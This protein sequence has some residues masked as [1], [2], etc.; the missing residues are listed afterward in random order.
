MTGS[1]TPARRNAILAVVVLA[2]LVLSVAL[3]PLHLLRGPLQSYAAHALQRE[4]T[5]EA[6]DVDF[7]RITR[8]QLDNVT[9]G[10]ATWAVDQP[11]AHA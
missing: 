9:I 8:L 7:G 3:F 11:M 4:V 6:L 5:I 10:N 2:V 1:R